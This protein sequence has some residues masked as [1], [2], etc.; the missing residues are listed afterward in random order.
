MPVY[1]SGR[2]LRHAKPEF[3]SDFYGSLPDLSCSSTS[4]SNGAVSEGGSSIARR[5][6]IVRRPLVPRLDEERF[7][8]ARSFSSLALPMSIT[9]DGEDEEERTTRPAS[10]Q[11]TYSQIAA[12]GEPPWNTQLIIESLN[13]SV[14]DLKQDLLDLQ[15]SVK[16]YRT[17]LEN[18]DEKT[19]KAWSLIEKFREGKTITPDPPRPPPIRVFKSGLQRGDSV[20]CQDLSCT[21][22]GIDRR[23]SI[24]SS[25]L[26]LLGVDKSRRSSL[27]PNR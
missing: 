3:G 23:W 18:H 15:S 14:S 10:P 21:G 26:S 22:A 4:A 27:M 5:P 11:T 20:S 6:V 8:E 16:Y 7:V 2:I 25:R 24:S 19:K 1:G 13:A 12:A 17:R 9:E